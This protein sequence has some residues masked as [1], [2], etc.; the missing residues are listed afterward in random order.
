M[1]IARAIVPLYIGRVKYVC[2]KK[3]PDGVAGSFERTWPPASGDFR[4]EFSLNP[5]ELEIHYAKYF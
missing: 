4:M 3:S 2:T 1:A 5:K